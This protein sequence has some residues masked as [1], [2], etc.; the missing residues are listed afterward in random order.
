LGI[1][2][3]QGGY[4]FFGT[5]AGLHANQRLDTS[6][7]KCNDQIF[8]LEVD[9][10]LILTVVVLLKSKFKNSARFVLRSFFVVM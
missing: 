5:A 1:L 3:Q 9:Q 6:G 4:H 8:R 10:I 7:G 2:A